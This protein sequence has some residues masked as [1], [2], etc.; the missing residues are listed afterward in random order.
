LKIKNKKL[1]I[2]YLKPVKMKKVLFILFMTVSVVGFSQSKKE[3]QFKSEI[4]E[5]S[6]ELN[7]T[8]EESDKALEFYLIRYNEWKAAKESDNK[9]ELNKESRKKFDDNM[10]GLLGEERFIA[11]KELDKEKKAEK[12]AAKEEDEDKNE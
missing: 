12:K 3:K 8:Q 7:W 10:K 4:S 5:L 11:Y 9:K 6:K 2:N 1:I